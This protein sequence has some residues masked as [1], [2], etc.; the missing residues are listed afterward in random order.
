MSNGSPS[1][2]AEI[3]PEDASAAFDDAPILGYLGLA[4]NYRPRPSLEPIEFLRRHLRQLPPHLLQMVFTVTTPMQRTVIPVIRNR[5][6]NYTSTQPENLSF[7]VA[8]KTWPLLWQG[9]GR[10]GQD[11]RQDEKRWADT[12][13]LGG[14]TQHVGKLGTLLGDYAEER[15]AER[16]RSLRRQAT[17][18]FVPEEEDSDDSDGSVFVEMT[19]VPEDSPEEARESF[20]RTIRERFIYGILESVDYDSVDGDDQWDKDNEKEDEE[21]WFD[22]EEESL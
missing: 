15:E 5:R 4:I 11:E 22:E 9:S 16:V 17:D 12:G 13:F 19:G 14:Q 1:S 3:Y 2:F 18:E 10:R 20:E 7:E 6:L 21:R 8:S